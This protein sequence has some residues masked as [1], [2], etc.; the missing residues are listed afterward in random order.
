[1]DEAVEIVAFRVS[2]TTALPKGAPAR[3]ATGSAEGTRGERSVWSFTRGERC[4]FAIVDRATLAA[5]DELRGPAIV[6]EPTA[7]TYLDAGFVARVHPHGHLVIERADAGASRDVVASEREA[8][9]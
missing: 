9:S 6:H 2:T 8:G 3:G 7:T 4:A 5:G 1:M